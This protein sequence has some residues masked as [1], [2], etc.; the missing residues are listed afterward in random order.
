MSVY[1]VLYLISV[2]IS[3]FLP[4]YEYFI[5]SIRMHVFLFLPTVLIGVCVY[6]GVYT[7]YTFS[8]LCIQWTVS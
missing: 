1:A 4:A 7:L 2:L 5:Y 6:V 3:V 8:R